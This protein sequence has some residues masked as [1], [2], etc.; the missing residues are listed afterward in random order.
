M[1]KLYLIIK[2]FYILV[3]QVITELFWY[4]TCLTTKKKCTY[5]L[6]TISPVKMYQQPKLFLTTTKYLLLTSH[7]SDF[8]S[9]QGS[10]SAANYYYQLAFHSKNISSRFIHT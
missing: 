3:Y 1:I 7:L 8:Y 2:N 9:G 4:L 10:A 6:H 5:I